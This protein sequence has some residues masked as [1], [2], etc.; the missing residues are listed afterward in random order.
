MIVAQRSEVGAVA[1]AH[2]S[3]LGRRRHVA[4]DEVGAGVDLGLG[5]DVRERSAGKVATVWLPAP[6]RLHRPRR[7]R[8]ELAEGHLAA[9]N[10]N[11][12]ERQRSERYAR[13]P[14]RRRKVRRPDRDEK[15]PGQRRCAKR[16]PQGGR[17]RFDGNADQP[18]RQP[19]MRGDVHGVRDVGADR[20]SVDPDPRDQDDVEDNID[21]QS[22]ERQRYSAPCLSHVVERRDEDR[23]EASQENVRRERPEYPRRRRELRTERHMRDRPGPC[24]H[25]SE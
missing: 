18:V 5:H 11:G 16:P 6:D 9:Q 2:V 22:C 25:E 8:P 19:Q 13:D 3:G 14:L 10:Q 23:T 7:E 21:G 15:T 1:V 12:R 4:E 17:E 20:C 24:G